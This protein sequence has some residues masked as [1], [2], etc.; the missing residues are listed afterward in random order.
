[1]ATND[2]SAKLTEES[3]TS[4]NDFI[5]YLG[6][7]PHGTALLSSHSIPKGDP[8]WKRTGV[9]DAK[10]VTWERDP[11]GPAVGQKGNRFLVRTSDLSAA[12]VAVLEKTPGFKRV[13]E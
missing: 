13:S 7:E 9:E 10:A 12:Q 1:M 4:D 2:A 6:E 5:E 8:L 11:M 3:K